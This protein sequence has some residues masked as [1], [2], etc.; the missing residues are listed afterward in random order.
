MDVGN[1]ALDLEPTP[2]RKTRKREDGSKGNERKRK[3]K[4][5]EHTMEKG[6]TC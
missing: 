3:H 4:W 5:L 6:T 1:G 2:K